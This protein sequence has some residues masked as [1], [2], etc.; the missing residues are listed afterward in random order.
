M[1]LTEVSKKLALQ[2]DAHIA[3]RRDIHLP[4]LF[5]TLMAKLARANELRLRRSTRDKRG[6][7]GLAG[8]AAPVLSP[9]GGNLPAKSRLHSLIRD[10]GPDLEHLAGQPG[11]VDGA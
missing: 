9:K 2:S 1:P 5:D 8:G 4:T 7:F 10:A 6:R 11:R 3:R